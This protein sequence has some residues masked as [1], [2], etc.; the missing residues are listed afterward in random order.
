MLSVSFI[1]SKE[2]KSTQQSLNYNNRCH[3]I[4]VIP[5]KVGKYI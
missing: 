5:N 3:I 2:I 4:N 1:N